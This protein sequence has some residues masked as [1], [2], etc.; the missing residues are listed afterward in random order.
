MQSSEQLADHLKEMVRVFE[1]CV[2]WAV[3]AILESEVRIKE[4]FFAAA[5]I[6]EGYNM[7]CMLPTANDRYHSLLTVGV[8][9]NDLPRLFPDEI[10]PKL[11]RDSMG[12]MAN[13][14]SGLF[15]AD[16]FFIAK[17]GH[18]KPSTPF[19]SDGAFTSHRDWSIQGKIEVHGQEL[20]FHFSIRDLRNMPDPVQKWE[21]PGPSSPEAGENPK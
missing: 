13:V 5:S 21:K 12:E 9:E 11:Q 19:F 4:P 6:P 17:F 8:E 16:D 10:D 15:V 1:G 20:L 3:R 14:I 2:I 18:L 7:F